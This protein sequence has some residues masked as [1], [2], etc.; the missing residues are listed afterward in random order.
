MGEGIFFPPQLQ[1]LSFKS[2][3]KRKSG[4]APDSTDTATLGWRPMEGSCNSIPQNWA[5]S[6]SGQLP[7]CLVNWNYRP[8]TSKDANHLQRQSAADQKTDTVLPRARKAKGAADGAE[9]LSG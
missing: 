5:F 1:E 6:L 8:Q 4:A 2:K 3:G 9:G 7:V